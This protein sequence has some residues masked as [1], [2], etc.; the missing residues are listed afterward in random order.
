M[1]ESTVKPLA[2]LLTSYYEHEK[3]LRKTSMQQI[4]CWRHKQTRQLLVVIRSENRNDSVYRRLLS[5]QHPHLP[6][7]YDVVST[8]ESLT[9]LEEYIE[10]ETLAD[11]MANHT[12]SKKSA[13]RYMRQICDAV[14]LL[15]KKG[16][17]HRDI[18]PA[19]I[20]LQNETVTLIDFGI[21][22]IIQEGRNHDTMA[23]GSVGYAAPEQFGFSQTC[24]TADIYALGV[25]LNEMLTGHH[26]T[27]K[28]A[29]GYAGKIIRK[30]LQIEPARRYKNVEQLIR[31]IRFL[32]YQ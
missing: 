16:I 12:L 19:N 13:Y 26:P 3:I 24:E 14:S 7:I 11:Y 21:A 2:C 31:S 8:P 22:R 17:I 28:I 25:L 29:P 32:S 9:V 30:C 23:L 6:A 15:H 4:D 1:N 27:E 18:K 10:G 20:M 5:V